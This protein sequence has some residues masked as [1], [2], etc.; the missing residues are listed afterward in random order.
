MTPRPPTAPAPVTAEDRAPR[1][2]APCPTCW[3]QRRIW[4]PVEAPNGEG[5][6]LVAVSCP[7][8]LGIGEVIS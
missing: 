8:C 5:P 1:P 4:T 3:G 6:V 7:G 2:W